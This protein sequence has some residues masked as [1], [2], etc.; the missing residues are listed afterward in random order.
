MQLDLLNNWNKSVDYFLLWHVVCVSPF[1]S[2]TQGRIRR[3]IW[4][5]NIFVQLVYRFVANAPHR[6]PQFT[7]NLTRA[8][9]TS[10]SLLCEVKRRNTHYLPRR[11]ASYA[12]NCI[13]DNHIYA[14]TYKVGTTK[15]F[16]ND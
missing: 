2:T 7:H 12:Q 13:E 15:L 6:P 3:P 14:R 11:R 9:T 1:D 5:E 16:D 10:H 4:T 8:C